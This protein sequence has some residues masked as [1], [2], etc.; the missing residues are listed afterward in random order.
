MKY[1][2]HERQIELV[3]GWLASG[4]DRTDCLT[5]CFQ[6]R[7]NVVQAHQLIDLAVARLTPQQ[8]RLLGSES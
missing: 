5:R 8:K 1:E 4:L 6:D 3:R 7:L 2:F